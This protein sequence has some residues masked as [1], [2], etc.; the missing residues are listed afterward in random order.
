MQVRIFSQKLLNP[1]QKQQN[2]TCKP[3]TKGQSEI[4]KYQSKIALL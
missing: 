2:I 3:A 1:K 4:Y